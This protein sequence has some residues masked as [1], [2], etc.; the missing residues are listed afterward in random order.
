MSSRLR[1]F[2]AIHFFLTLWSAIFPQPK[3]S[4]LPPASFPQL[5]YSS[6]D[7]FNQ[8]KYSAALKLLEENSRLARTSDEKMNYHINLANARASLG[9][10][11]EALEEYQKGLI[12]ATDS[13]EENNIKYCETSIKIINLY[14]QAKSDKQQ[15][16][17]ELAIKKFKEAITYCDSVKNRYLKVKC[18]RRMSYIYLD[19]K[20]PNPEEFLKNSI[21]ANNIAKEIKLSYEIILTFMNIGHYY[22][23]SGN[24]SLAINYFTQALA[25]IN[26]DTLPSDIFDIYYNLGVVYNDTGNFNKSIEYFNQALSLISS[27]E[28][29]PYF[30]ATLNNLGFSYVKK[31]LLSGQ[32]EDFNQAFDFFLKALKANEKAGNTEIQVAILNNIGSLKA[33][34]EENLDALYYLNRARNLAETQKFTNYLS[35]IYTNIG[36]IYSRLGDYQ[37]STVYYDKAINLALTENENKTL[38]ESYL[39]KGNLLKKQGNLQSAKFYYLNS[40]NIIESLRAS[41]SSEEDKANFLGT[42][43]RLDA[44]FNLID[45]LVKESRETKSSRPLEEAF[46]YLERARARV[47]LEQIA[48]AK[49]AE[50]LPA[51]IKLI[52]QEKEMMSELSRLYTRLLSPSLSEEDRT[53]A[54]KEI[55]VLEMRLENLKRQIR[56]QNP[57]YA[58]LTY[59]DIINYRQ[60]EKEFVDRKTAIFSFMVGREASYA[61]CLSKN[62]LKVYPIPS[63][64]ELRQKIIAYR[65][66]ISDVDNRDFQLGFEIYRSLLEPGLTENVSHLIIVPDNLLNLLPFE[67]LK[68]SGQPGDWLINHYNLSYAPSLSSLRE[69]LH[70]QNRYGRKK[71]N[72]TLLAVGDPYYG[73]FEQRSTSLSSRQLF[74][75]FYSL[76]DIR[77]YRLKYASDE[78]NRIS[79]LFPRSTVLEREKASEDLIKSAQLANYRIIHFAVHGLIDDQKPARSAL[80]LTLDN[81]PNEDGF[82]Q[83]REI[84]NLKLNADLVVL[85]ACQ[86]GLGQ[87]IRG[88]GLESLSRAFFFAGSSSVL[89]SLWAINDQVSSQF[90]ERFYLHL[91]SSETLNEALRKAKLEMI[92]SPV[93]S[94]P[95]YW[96]PFIL[97]GN[98]QIKITRPVP[99]SQLLVIA[100]TIAG[101]VFGT[102]LII[103]RKHPLSSDRNN[104]R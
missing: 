86:T 100:L 56:S 38:W 103:K 9:Q 3:S 75:D 55:K 52:N 17:D 70:L 26:E 83:M 29:N 94:H 51:N 6:L 4:V 61:F 76:S 104:G 33:H 65:R 63:Q 2:I 53:S 18:L 69:L 96:A 13:G 71:P 85:S 43:K 12:Y 80:V 72:R 15:G 40:I 31:G 7:L 41:L 79:R 49:I 58:K 45:L 91:K 23:S 36:I 21:E 24:L 8:G 54:L 64:E 47:F 44:Y 81:D 57:A 89:T 20:P 98:G 10:I 93:V 62:G 14:N 11:N 74:Q 67:A 30:S 32:K 59:P 97:H 42:D 99:N 82:L 50:N 60:A 87:F 78:I 28:S 37:N 92:A 27:D 102:I 1:Y 68:P 84:M 5:L 39:E 101:L 88:E 34:L 46:L 95:Y 16:L 66:A 25:F 48:D 73:E 19:E 35:S 77:F 22:Y 90:M